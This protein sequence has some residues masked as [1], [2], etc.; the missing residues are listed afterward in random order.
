M[1][2]IEAGRRFELVKG[3]VTTT[4]LVMYAGAS[5][6]FN[7][8]HYDADFAR[9]AG[10]PSVIAH[11]MLTMG[12]AGQL[13]TEWGGPRCDVR[14]LSARFVAPVH[15]G[16]TVTL[17]GVAE[18]VEQEAGARRVSIAFRGA[19]GDREVIVGRGVVRVPD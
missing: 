18:S 11:G 12:F 2:G 13:L 9:S 15:P 5:G 8:I 7:R 3:P 14:S 10:H 6:D 17:A 16:D 1:A 19:V 4:Q